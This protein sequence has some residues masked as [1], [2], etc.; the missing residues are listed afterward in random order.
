MQTTKKKLHNKTAH[1]FS[2]GK[3]KA[4]AICSACGEKYVW[5]G[6]GV[7]REAQR[8]AKRHECASSDTVSTE[9]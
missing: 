8:W 2:D 9:Q 3:D 7:W 1:A 4:S 5:L 6:A